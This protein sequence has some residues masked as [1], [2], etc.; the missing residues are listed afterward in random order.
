MDGMISLTSDTKEA[1]IVL[2]NFLR[3]EVVQFPLCGTIDVFGLIKDEIEVFLEVIHD[4]I[5]VLVEVFLVETS[6]EDWT[7]RFK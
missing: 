5:E 3:I 1:L 2:E 6:E 7:L 4:I